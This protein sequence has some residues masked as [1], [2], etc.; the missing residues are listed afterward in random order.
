DDHEEVRAATGAML[1]ELHHKVA[2]AGNAMEA[3]AALSDGAARCDLLISDYAM[4][5]MSG[6]ELIRQARSLRPGLPS[7]I[8]TGYAQGD[9]VVG[10]EDSVEVLFKP[11]TLEELSAA[12]DRAVQQGSAHGS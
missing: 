1:E 4:P 8:I 7:L 5:K 10:S 2:Q 3:V 6:I 12:I 11:F 9:G